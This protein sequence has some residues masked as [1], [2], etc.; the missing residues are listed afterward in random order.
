MRVASGSENA[1]APIPQP[2][3]VD[4]R[5]NGAVSREVSKRMQPTLT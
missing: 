5:L 4:S 2:G 3:S 1:G